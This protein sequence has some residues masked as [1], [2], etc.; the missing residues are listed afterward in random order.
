VVG[1][2]IVDRMFTEEQWQMYIPSLS[3]SIPRSLGPSRTLARSLDT[4]VLTRLTPSH[5]R[6]L[7]RFTSLAHSLSFSTPR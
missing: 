2:Y 5:S 7:A 6:T 1:K 3:L 4:L